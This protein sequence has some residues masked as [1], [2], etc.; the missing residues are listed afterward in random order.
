M[1]N[2]SR[3]IQLASLMILAV[4]ALAPSKAS[5][6]SSKFGCDTYYDNFEDGHVGCILMSP[7]AC[8]CRYMCR[9][10]QEVVKMTCDS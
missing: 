5:A 8:I 2:K 9:D 10:G 6:A 3:M 7:D 4:A 1:L